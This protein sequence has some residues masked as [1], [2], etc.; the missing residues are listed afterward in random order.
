M[1]A[2]A[3]LAAAYLEDRYGAP[4]TLMALLVGL[5]LNFLG[6]D[7]RLSPGLGIASG[8]SLRLGIVLLG[9]RVTLGQIVDLGPLALIAILGIVTLTIAF[10]VVMAR[11]T[12]VDAA[13]GAL[14]GAAVAI[15]GASAALA[16]AAT[17]GE[18]R[19]GKAQLAQI[20]V[21]I[22]AMSAMAMFL[23]PIGAHL[24]GLNDRQAGFLFGAAI[25]DVAQAIGAGYSYSPPAGETAA[26]V[27]L[28]RVALLAPILAVVALA[29]PNQDHRA[30]LARLPLFVVGFFATAA[31]NSAALIPPF[32]AHS[33]EVTA[34]MLLAGAV[35]ATGIRAPM[36]AL[37][38]G[39][40]KP[41]A[42]LAAATV[43]SLFSSTIAACWLI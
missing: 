6:T 26:I 31:A 36:A 8:A 17:L 37:K 21:G 9:T 16:V 28:T 39:G 20:L 24:I 30:R 11:L 23:Y 22:A 29:F 13:F 25:H 3:T 42:I 40:I 34:T 12:D 15:C 32:L 35:A 41:I 43:L 1:V 33:A 10:A 2:A 4:L 5:A 18:R 19:I 27:K 14:A 7:Q 38:A